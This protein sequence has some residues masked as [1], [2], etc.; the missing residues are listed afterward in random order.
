M[1]RALGWMCWQVVMHWTGA[2]PSSA[3]SAWMLAWA[4]N[5]ANDPLKQLAKSQ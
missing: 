1:K 3:M 5:H 2:W 4:G